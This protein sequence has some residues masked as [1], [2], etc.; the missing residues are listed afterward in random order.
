MYTKG[1]MLFLY[2]ETPAHPGTGESQTADLAIQRNETSSWPIVYS[3]SLKGGLRSASPHETT[4]DKW[5]RIIAFG[6]DLSEQGGDDADGGGDPA[7]EGAETAAANG[8]IRL[9]VKDRPRGALS[10]NEANIIAFPVVSLAG[11]FAWITCAE[12]LRTLQRTWLRLPDA[13]M[14]AAC[15]WQPP[16]LSEQQAVWKTGSA[17]EVGGDQK[18]LV[19]Q[20]AV[21]EPYGGEKAKDAQ[22]G[23][24]AFAK[25]LA[26]QALQGQPA[27]SVARLKDA[28]VLVNDTTFTNLVAGGIHVVTR[29]KLSDET[30]T[31]EQGPWDEELLPAETILFAPIL[32]EAANLPKSVAA[33]PAL[34][35]AGS[36]LD[37]F[38]RKVVSR[39]GKPRH[40]QL[41]AGATVGWGFMAA[42]LNPAPTPAAP[43]NGG[44]P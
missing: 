1:A 7:P 44:Q 40:V 28:L 11:V 33:A 20:D 30:G 15:A 31:V 39:D 23:L 41:G 16:V 9:E 3:S 27:G 2:A 34:T 22:D 26:G 32:A 36:V 14:P 10:I 13:P 17:L 38:G 6:Y 18:R 35:D 29:V 4:A 42:T 24:K 25:W 21:L 43:A 19:L 5:K 37:Y 12:A 8:A